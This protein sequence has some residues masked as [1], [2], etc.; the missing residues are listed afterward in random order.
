MGEKAPVIGVFLEQIKE[1]IAIQAQQQS[2][3]ARPHGHT[4]R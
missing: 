4:P 3:T 2:I 1:A